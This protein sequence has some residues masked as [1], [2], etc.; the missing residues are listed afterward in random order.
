MV[1]TR[2]ALLGAG[3]A[4]G[5]AGLPACGRS[6]EYPRGAL[7]IATG[8]RGG[9]YYAYG[10]GI[11]E[12]IRERLP[13]LQPE[14]LTTAASIEN[15]R[16]VAAGQAEVGFSLADSA[17]LGFAGMGPFAAALPITALMRLYDNYL[18]LVVPAQTAIS[19]VGDLR[20]QAVSVGAAG[21]GTELTVTRLLMAAGLDPERDMRV[22][23]LGVDESAT[24]M[25]ARQLDAFFFSGGVPTSAIYD[26]AA[27]LPV[28]LIELGSLA[29]KM[30]R[31]FGELYAVRTIPASAYRLVAPVATIGVPN[32]LVVHANMDEGLAY[33]LVRAMFAGQA[34][35]ADAHPEGRRL[36]RRSAINTVPLPLHPGAARYFQDSKP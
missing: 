15:I 14:I 30:R 34:R 12:V 3:F 19:S 1:L 7:R 10:G 31:M 32:Y 35:L 23:R 29:D 36:D 28:R 2:R 17:A 8:G 13:G 9:V 4:V 16:L 25:S 33:Q 26:L 11:V 20:G 22:S 21:S 6:P 27:L 24:S 5:L 18:H